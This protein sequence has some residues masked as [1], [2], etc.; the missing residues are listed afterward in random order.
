[1][2]SKVI[3]IRDDVES[4][5]PQW[6]NVKHKQNS[7]PRGFTTSMQAVRSGNDVSAQADASLTNQAP[8]N[9]PAQELLPAF[10]CV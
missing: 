3:S 1:L 5:C 6:P 7:V 4:E 2:R 8:M 9:T 10:L